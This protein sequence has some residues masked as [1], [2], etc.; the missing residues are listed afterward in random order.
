MIFISFQAEP[1]EADDFSRP[2][3]PSRNQRP[4]D[5][6]RGGVGDRPD[7]V[8]RGGFGPGNSVRYPD[9]QQIFI[10]NLPFDM[11]EADLREHFAGLSCKFTKLNLLI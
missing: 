7:F 8:R 10:G 9:N 3:R 5:E 11:T 1:A 4:R 2:A 6:D